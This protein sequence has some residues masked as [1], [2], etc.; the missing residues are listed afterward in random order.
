MTD[1]CLL[2]DGDIDDCRIWRHRGYQRQR[3]SPPTATRSLHLFSSLTGSSLPPSLPPSFLPSFLLLSFSILN[4]SLPQ[5]IL[6]HYRS[7]SMSSS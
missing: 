1:F 7:G 4:I 3:E 6:P 2:H 5:L